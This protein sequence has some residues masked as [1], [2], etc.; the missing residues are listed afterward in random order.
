VFSV[1]ALLSGCYSLRLD[2]AQY[3]AP[4]SCPLTVTD[5]RPDPSAIVGSEITFTIVP[6]LAEVLKSKLCRSAAISAF[7]AR[8]TTV[9]RVTRAEVTSFGFVGS[10][11]MLTV[12]GTMSAD[13]QKWSVVARATV[14]TATPERFWP[15]LLNATLDDFVK[16]VEEQLP[17]QP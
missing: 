2:M 17:R 12:E 5:A 7:V 6:P 9:I 4:A 8:N 10:T 14:D 3:A 1:F 11:K 15:E 13:F 16:R